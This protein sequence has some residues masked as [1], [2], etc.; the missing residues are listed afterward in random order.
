MKKTTRPASSVVLGDFLRSKR[1]KVGLT[2]KQVADR[3]GYSTPQFVSAWERAEREPPMSVIWSLANIYNI[4]AEKIFDVM[5]TYRRQ[6]VEQALRAE[7]LA[8]RPRSKARN[9]VGRS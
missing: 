4:S 9:S 6:M 1:E 5:V 2:Q 8:L 3:L 7:F